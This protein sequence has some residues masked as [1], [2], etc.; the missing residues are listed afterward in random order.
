[1][2]ISSSTG[3][4][5]GTY[6]SV[7]VPVPPLLLDSRSGTKSLRVSNNLVS[8]N[9]CVLAPFS[10]IKRLL[11][12]TAALLL[13]RPSL[14]LFIVPTT[15]LL[16]LENKEEEEDEHSDLTPE[17][18][19]E[20]FDL[21]AN[22]TGAHFTHPAAQ[23][24]GLIPTSLDICVGEEKLT[25]SILDADTKLVAALIASIS[26]CLSL[27]VCVCLCV[28]LSFV[29]SQN[30]SYLYF[31]QRQKNNNQRPSCFKQDSTRLLFI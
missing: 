4:K 18:E 30:V 15:N 28:S 24:Q 21:I 12:T 3:V 13:L 11:T 8:A 22:E 31:L 7:P 2:S 29:R 1:M 19:E 16:E 23:K 26:L 27:Y 9:L 17:E 5:S 20:P 10:S 14:A 25:A 6:I